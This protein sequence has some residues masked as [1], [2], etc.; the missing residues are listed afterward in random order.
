M[1]V[2]TS[3]KP[4]WS[5]L[6]E[7]ARGCK[8]RTTA[9][10]NCLRSCCGSPHLGRAVSTSRRRRE[11]LRPCMGRQVCNWSHRTIRRRNR[12]FLEIR[13]SNSLRSLPVCH[14]F[15]RP[16]NPRF[17]FNNPSARQSENYEP[18]SPGLTLV[19]CARVVCS[20][21]RAPLPHTS[22]RCGR[23]ITVTDCV[24]CECN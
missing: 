19:S 4:A 15:R 10:P 9:R 3:V 12:S 5:T 13:S 24:V 16:K 23:D 18:S 2:N 17:M 22:S 8:L 6:E 1:A 20:C 14:R 7:P 21:G 11:S